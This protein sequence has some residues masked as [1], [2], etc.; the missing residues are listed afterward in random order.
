[1]TTCAKEKED[2]WEKLPFITTQWAGCDVD[3]HQLPQRFL[4]CSAARLRWVCRER[5]CH[6][7]HT[8]TR[9]ERYPGIHRPPT[10]SAELPGCS[11]DN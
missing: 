2:E 11:K 6:N 7:T 10:W 8:H 4:P 3:I 1:M 5:K 9:A